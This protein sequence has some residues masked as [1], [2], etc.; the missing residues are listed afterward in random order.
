MKTIEA[1]VL[2]LLVISALGLGPDVFAD[3]L[4][5]VEDRQVLGA[6]SYRIHCLNCHG[7]SGTGNGPMAELLK[8]V[9]AD[10]TRL[11]ARNDGEFPAQ[12]IY[13]TIDGRQEL[14]S[15]GSREM[16]VWG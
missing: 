8:I 16:P 5:E 14:A 15:H 3:E 11:A 9:P 6:L 13:Q 2:A 1:S 4:P 10:L 7:S 12:R